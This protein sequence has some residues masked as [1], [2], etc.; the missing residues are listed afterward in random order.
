TITVSAATNAGTL[1]APATVC[2]TANTG[3]LNLSGYTGAINKWQSS[4]DNGTTWTD[5]ASTAASFTYNNLNATT[6]FRTQVQNAVC[7]PLFS[8][9]V[10]ITVLQPVSTA[11]AGPDQQLCNTSAAAMAATTP[12]SGN[13]SWAQLTGPNTASFVNNT[14]PHTV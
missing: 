12:T 13:G 11:S 1:A 10:T 14:D 5:I 3:T 7:A 8:S 4:T 2:A 9:P 6:L